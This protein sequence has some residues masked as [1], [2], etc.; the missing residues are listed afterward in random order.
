M[1]WIT[2]SSVR[3]T[4]SSCPNCGVMMRGILPSADHHSIHCSKLWYAFGRRHCNTSKLR[5][6][7]GER[8]RRVATI[9]RLVAKRIGRTRIH[10]ASH[11]PRGDNLLICSRRSRQNHLVTAGYSPAYPHKPN[12][13]GLTPPPS[14][15]TPPSGRPFHPSPDHLRARTRRGGSEMG[16]DETGV[17]ATAGVGEARMEPACGDLTKSCS[18][19]VLRRAG[20]RKGPTGR[21]VGLSALLAWAGGRPGPI[22]PPSSS[23]LA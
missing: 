14:T 6:R 7:P 18:Q 1:R 11:D 15:T 10:Y 21:A 9:F 2:F 12:H 3:E 5:D 16:P 13:L 4:D 23:T 17:R 19:I 20:R 8:P 22:P